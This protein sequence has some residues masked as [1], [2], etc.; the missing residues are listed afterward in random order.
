MNIAGIDANLLVV[1]DAV[2]AERSATRAARRLNVTQSAVSNALARLRARLGDRLVV[3]SGRG[4]VPTP[5][6]LAMAARLRAGL[7]ELE[8]A[9]GGGPG[10]D[11]ATSTREFTFADSEEFSQLPELAAAFAR[12]LPRAVLRLSVV[13]DLPAALAAARADLGLGPLGLA[14]PGLRKRALY[15]EEMVR[16]A[17]RDHPAWRRGPAALARCRRAVV[18]ITGAPRATTPGPAGPVAMRVPTFV[19]AALAVSESDLVAEVPAHLARSIGRLLPLRAAALG[20]EPVPVALYWHDRT[21]DDEGARFVR[22]LVAE[23]ITGA[24]RRAGA[25]PR[26]GRG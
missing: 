9:V 2:L 7:A 15:E 19:A 8:A 5:R 22:R 16:I 26:E 25:G 6:A 20:A 3:R 18:E 1:L 17:R 12:G 11:P 14:G 23:T 4:L 21:H 24:G 10:F 13:D